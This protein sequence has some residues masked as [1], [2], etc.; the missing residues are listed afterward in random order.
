MFLREI[1]IE[2]LSVDASFIFSIKDRTYVWLTLMLDPSLPNDVWKW[3]NFFSGA[4]HSL[5]NFDL[6]KVSRSIL[7][8]ADVITP[9]SSA[10]KFSSFLEFARSP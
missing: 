2:D 9:S 10:N 4:F 7:N 1:G 6:S 8:S 5:P 3:S